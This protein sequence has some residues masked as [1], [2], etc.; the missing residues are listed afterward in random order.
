MLKIYPVEA[1]ADIEIVKQ[2]FGEYLAFLKEEFCDYA[3]LPWVI[4][5]Y[6]DFEEEIANLPDRFKKPKGYILV[7]IYEEQPAGCVAM[8]ELE[9]GACEMKRLF[10][11]PE[12]RRKGVGTALCKAI[13]ERAK[14]ID[15]THMRLTTALERPQRLYKSL[16]FK[17]IAAYRDVP[18][19]GVVFMELKL[20]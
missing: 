5:Y 7:A 15:Y 13:I 19:D 3:E 16:E 11:R 14:V 12:Y 17:M 2:L 6:E 4:E 20:E 8:G 10:V 9:A 1:G 18:I